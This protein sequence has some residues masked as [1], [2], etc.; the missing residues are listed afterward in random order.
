MKKKLKIYF[1]WK[2]KNLFNIKCKDI[3]DSSIKKADKRR[4]DE[5]PIENKL[6]KNRSLPNLINLKST[7]YRNL[8]KNFPKEMENLN[9]WKMKMNNIKP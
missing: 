6:K 2:T 1:F 3:F 9:R 5:E 8:N 7:N 4:K